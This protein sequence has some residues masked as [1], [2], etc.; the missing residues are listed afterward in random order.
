M[1]KPELL[2]L[3]RLLSGLETILLYSGRQHLNE[4][5]K[6]DYL[7]DDISWSVAIIEREVLGN[8]NCDPTL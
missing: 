4:R 3:M 6:I 8:G 5:D 1:S 7:L 2:R